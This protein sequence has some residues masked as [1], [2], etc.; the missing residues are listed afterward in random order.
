MFKVQDISKRR[1][2]WKDCIGWR[3]DF[4]EYLSTVEAPSG[5]ANLQSAFKVESGNQWPLR[6]QPFVYCQPISFKGGT[7]RWPVI[8]TTIAKTE[9]IDWW[10]RTQID[11]VEII[12]RWMKTTIAT[13]KIEYYKHDR[14]AWG[15]TLVMNISCKGLKLKVVNRWSRMGTKT[16]QVIDSQW[17]M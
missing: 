3:Y 13:K 9:L 17:E 10:L 15:K 7:N 14:F 12:D 4:K 16:I 1:H 8:K 5:K 11:V 2:Q 6:L